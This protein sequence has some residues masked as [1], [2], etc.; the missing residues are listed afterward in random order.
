MRS[1]I[2]RISPQRGHLERDPPHQISPETDRPA[3][4]FKKDPKDAP[5]RVKN[6]IVSQEFIV[7]DLPLNPD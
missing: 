7:A 5:K 2:L 1:Q 4:T 3:T 6:A